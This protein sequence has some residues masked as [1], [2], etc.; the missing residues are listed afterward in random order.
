MHFQSFRNSRTSR[1]V[2]FPRDKAQLFT[3]KSEIVTLER[4]KRNIDMRLTIQQT[5]RVTTAKQNSAFKSYK[6]LYE[7]KHT[8]Q[9]Q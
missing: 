7:K 8:N 9:Y 2:Y 5:K 3:Q 1:N 6:Y 4:R